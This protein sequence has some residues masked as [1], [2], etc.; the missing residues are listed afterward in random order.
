MTIDDASANN[1]FKFS[2]LLDWVLTHPSYHT[3]ILHL[4]LNINAAAA[5]GESDPVTR[6]MALGF[7]R[8]QV[9]EALT[10]CGG[11]TTLAASYLFQSNTL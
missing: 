9:R 10:V 11:D 7:T 6:L 8:E 3:S 2:F 5:S 1:A 4:N